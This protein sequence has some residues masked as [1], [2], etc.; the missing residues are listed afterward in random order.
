MSGAEDRP[1]FLIGAQR[2]GSSLLRNMLN[3]HPKI[4][5]P[6][7]RGVDL[8]MPFVGDDGSIPRALGPYLH[9]LESN[10]AFL[11]EGQAVDATLALPDLVRSFLRQS[12]ERTAKPFAMG[13]VHRNFDRLPYL[14]PEAKFVYLLRDGRDVTRSGAVLGW[15]NDFWTAAEAWL[16]AE[17]RWD[18]MRERLAADRYV[19]VRYEDLVSEPVPELERICA[20]IGTPYDAAIFDYVDTSN[21]G[22]PDPSLAGQ[23]RRKLSDDEIRL[24]EARMGDRL[25]ARSYE[26]SGLPRLHVSAAMAKS[27]ERR[28]RWVRRWNEIRRIGA[29]DFT[30]EVATRRL[31]WRSWNR[32]IR[33]RTDRRHPTGG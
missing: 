5:F 17:E 19:E 30:L 26:L 12:L 23:W 29:V 20:L 9:E 31:G 10:G 8:A 14:W 24:T 18:R 33:R 3:S 16:L 27:L 15:G 22:K 28:S 32:V 13:T 4:C 25:E 21:F 6:R 7:H 11:A 1:I 2:S